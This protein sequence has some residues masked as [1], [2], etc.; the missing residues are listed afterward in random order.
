MRV[1]QFCPRLVGVPVLVSAT[2]LLPLSP[3]TVSKVATQKRRTYRHLQRTR[4]RKNFIINHR[5][6]CR[7]VMRDERRSSDCPAAFCRAAA[8]PKDP[9]YLLWLSRIHTVTP[10]CLCLYAFT[11]VHLNHAI[12]IPLLHVSTIYAPH[13]NT[14][15]LTPVQHQYAPSC[16]A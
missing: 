15:H 3:P 13:T 10:L 14:R 16:D 6:R 1:N 2:L 7:Q 11:F 8:F 4:K 9:I 5:W 12:H